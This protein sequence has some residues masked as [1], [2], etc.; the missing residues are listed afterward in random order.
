MD[1][2]GSDEFGQEAREDIGEENDTCWQP[3]G[4]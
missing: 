4:G 3:R 2:V 1:E